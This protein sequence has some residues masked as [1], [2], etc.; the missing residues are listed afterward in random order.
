[1]ASRTMYVVAIPVVAGMGAIAFSTASVRAEPVRVALASP[2]AAAMPA[3][4][5]SDAGV[6]TLSAPPR[7]SEEM[8]QKRFGPVAEYL[9][10]ILGRKVV[11]KHPGSWGVY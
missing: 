1:M 6:I 2:E 3:S 9:S 4:P 8:G 11:Y 10:K 7:D 5:A